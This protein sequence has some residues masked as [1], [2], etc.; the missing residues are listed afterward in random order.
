MRQFTVFTASTEH[1]SK[2]INTITYTCFDIQGGASLYFLPPSTS[3]FMYMHGID[4]L[5]SHELKGASLLDM[6]FTS[7][8]WSIMLTKKAGNNSNHIMKEKNP[9]SFTG[10]GTRTNYE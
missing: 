8:V 3:Y 1:D 5:G 6:T 10:S 4:F 9:D 7:I 2:T